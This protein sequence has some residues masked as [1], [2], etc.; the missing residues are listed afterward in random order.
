ML[1]PC[2]FMVPTQLAFPSLM[3]VQ[4]LVP[5]PFNVS[6]DMQVLYEFAQSLVSAKY[7][8]GHPCLLWQ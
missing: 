8:K 4:E 2:S 5:A 7:A 3:R 1:A 6:I